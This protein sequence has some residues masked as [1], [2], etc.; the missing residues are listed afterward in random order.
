MNSIKLFLVGVIIIFSPIN[1]AVSQQQEPAYCVVVGTFA[2]RDNAARLA[3]D[4]NQSETVEYQYLYSKQN[5]IYYVYQSTSYGRKKAIEVVL[6]LRNRPKFWDAWLKKIPEEATEV[7]STQ[8]ASL[9]VDLDID[10][11]VPKAPPSLKQ[12]AQST[13]SKTEVFMN[14]FDSKNYRAVDGIVKVV[15]A[16]SLKAID[17]L[18]GNEHTV[19]ATPQNRGG[20]A[21]LVC[22]IFG[23]RRIQHEIDLLD[24]ISTA[25]GIAE[26]IGTSIVVHFDLIKYQRGDIVTLFNVYFYN[27]ASIMLRESQYQL[28]ELLSMLQSNPTMKVRLHGHSNGNYFG[29]II[30]PGSEENFFSLAKGAHKIV[31][32]A[33]LLSMK[34]AEIVRRYMIKNGIDPYRILVKSWGGKRPVYDRHSINAKRNLRV[35]VEIIEE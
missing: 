3:K 32:S 29:K 27:D 35:D 4:L 12:P 31:G 21:L 9:A 1:H 6:E 33:K 16:Q 14:I 28:N 22:D 34:R 7:V 26:R 17:E 24:P 13:F 18:R 23:Y 5:E 19:I 20:R 11:S 10:S 2:I 8:P 25:P 30:V 15:D